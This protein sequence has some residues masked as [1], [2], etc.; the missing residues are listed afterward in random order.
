MMHA[1]SKALRR[2]RILIQVLTVVLV[3]LASWGIIT[4][5]VPSSLNKQTRHPY[6]R[7]VD[8]PNSTDST[9]KFMHSASAA[10][11]EA[12]RI[13]LQIYKELIGHYKK[14]ILVGLADMENKGDSAISVGEFEALSKLG[15][16]VVY[17]CSIRKCGNFGRAKK[18]LRNETEPVVILTSG[19][20]NTCIWRNPCQQ[21]EKL[22]RAFPDREILVFPQSVNFTSIQEM[23]AHAA[24]M[25][26]PNITYLFRDHKSY[27]IFVNSRMFQYNKA[28]LCPDAAMQI[29]MM[30]PPIEPT[31]DIVWLKRADMESLHSRLPEFPPNLTITVE[32]WRDIKVPL[33]MNLKQ[34]SYKRLMAGF[35]FLSRGKVIVS[36]RLHGHILSVLLGKPNVMLD[37]S[38][39]KVSSFHETWTPNVDS[40]LLASNATDALKKA[41]YLLQKYY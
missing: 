26:H 5:I 37:N 14:A 31:H 19:G 32:D 24:A 22:V 10:V 34:T 17:Y 12:Q 18:V 20:G 7:L 28:V 6:S 39:K 8:L 30:H 16:E 15:I 13:Q 27:N 1:G 29:G 38:Y 41:L 33:G 9:M 2:P 21:R 36:D 23:K 4:N 11:Q 35:T 3:V 25:K 40:V